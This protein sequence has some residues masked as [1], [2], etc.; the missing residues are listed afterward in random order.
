MDSFE[1]AQ[2][3]NVELKCYANSDSYVAYVMFESQVRAE[4]GLASNRTESHSSVTEFTRLAGR[5]HGLYFQT[6]LMREE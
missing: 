1:H 3:V 2:S 4:S 5:T 6:V